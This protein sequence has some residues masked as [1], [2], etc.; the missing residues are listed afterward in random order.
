MFAAPI[1]AGGAH[2]ALH[3]VENQQDIVF[4]GNLSQFLQPFT[5]EMVVA[6]LTL[7]RLDDDGANVDVAFFDELVDL[8]L[9]FLFALDHVPFAFR[10]RKRKI[11]GGT[12]DAGPI[13][14]RKQIR[15][16]RVGIGQAHRV[17]AAPMKSASEMQNLRAAFAVTCG[18][19]LPDFPIH[20]G[21]QTILHRKSAAVDEQVTLERWQ[22]DDTLEG[23]YEFSVTSRINIRVGNLHFRRAQQIAL[24]LRIIEIWVV[25]P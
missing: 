8:A 10:F 7:D 20:R 16:A 18:H 6:A 22:T 4:V 15:L 23:R 24:Y 11:N 19:V 14:F 13:K 25:K 5:A 12:R 3:F 17:T 9:G 21:F 2:A 1:A